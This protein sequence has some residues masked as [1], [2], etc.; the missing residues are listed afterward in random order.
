MVTFGALEPTW[1]I[2][3]PAKLL[4][5]CGGSKA[6]SL[7]LDPV[8]ARRWSSAGGAAGKWFR[9]AARRLALVGATAALAVFVRAKRYRLKD[10]KEEWL[11]YERIFKILGDAKS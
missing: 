4:N 2:S 6:A 5:D 7:G 3:I 1:P 10:G 11:R 9:R 8:G